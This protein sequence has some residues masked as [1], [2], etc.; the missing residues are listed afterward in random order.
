M[1]PRETLCSRRCIGAFRAAPHGTGGTRN[2]ARYQ[3]RSDRA[4]LRSACARAHAAVRVGAGVLPGF[5]C[6][7]HGARP[8][9]ARDRARG[10]RGAPAL[11]RARARLPA[12]GVRAVPC[13]AAAGVFLQ[14]AWVLPQLRH[15]AHGREYAA[16]GRWGVWPAAGAAM[17]AE[18][19]AAVAL[20]VRPKAACAAE[21]HAQR[22]LGRF[23][24]QMLP[25]QTAV[26]AATKWVRNRVRRDKPQAGPCQG[27]SRP[28]DDLVCVQIL[29][30]RFSQAY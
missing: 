4:D 12:R 15:A 30:S 13:R 9:A 29:A 19:P 10:V 17:G 20:A 18:C 2:V 8:P 23:C 6:A 1:R 22:Q 14:E 21:R 27:P 5:H 28:P 3:R 11:R 25:G 26:I 16:P 24:W 7:S